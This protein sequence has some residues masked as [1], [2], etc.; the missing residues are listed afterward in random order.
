MPT[1]ASAKICS[2]CICQYG[3]YMDSWR[4][5][6]EAECPSPYVADHVPPEPSGP[7]PS[8]GA[9]VGPTKIRT[10]GA[11][12]DPSKR[13]HA[14]EGCST[15]AAADDGGSISSSV[16]RAAAKSAALRVIGLGQPA[17]VG[18][19]AS[20]SAGPALPTPVSP[21]QCTR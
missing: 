17:S 2:G 4:P 5:R 16:E 9:A 3:P 8:T 7:R 18:S 12:A 11:A 14:I 20:M 19:C 6:F 10:G 15:P 13:L 1:L 21:N